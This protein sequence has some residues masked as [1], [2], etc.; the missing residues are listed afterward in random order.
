MIRL[1]IYY[2]S[3]PGTPLEQGPLARLLAELDAGLPEPLQERSYF[4]S[5]NEIAAKFLRDG[6]IVYAADNAQ[7]LVGIAVVYADSSRYSRAYETYIGVLSSHRRQGIG[8]VLSLMEIDLCRAAG[9]R[10]IMTNCDPRNDAKMAMNQT[11]GYVRVGEA[12]EIKKIEQMN[13]KWVGKA[14]FVKDWA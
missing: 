5:F 1:P 2:R 11:L 3:H 13:P 14:F 4:S 9:V 12:E 8:K 10:G 7:R 6:L